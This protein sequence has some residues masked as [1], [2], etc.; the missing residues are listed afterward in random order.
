MGGSLKRVSGRDAACGWAVGQLDEDKRRR[1]V[2]CDLRHVAV[3]QEQQR[4]IRRAELWASVMALAG[5]LG[6]HY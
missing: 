6:V 3:E 5:L 2:V 4:R 1:A